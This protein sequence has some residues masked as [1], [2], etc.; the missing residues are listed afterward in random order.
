M[1]TSKERYGYG[2]HCRC[3]FGELQLSLMVARD[4]SSGLIVAK[5]SCRDG[6]ITSELAEAIGIKEA[7]IW[8]K[9]NMEQL[10]LIETDCL[11]IIKAIRCSFINLSYLG[12]VIDECKILLSELNNFHVTLK[13]LRRSANKLVHFLT[14]QNSY[15]ADRISG[16]IQSES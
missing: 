3:N 8:V 13:F 1:G 6:C 7:L 5:S 9:D 14:R 2:Q 16:L 11:S 12:R 10:A 4:H 15:I